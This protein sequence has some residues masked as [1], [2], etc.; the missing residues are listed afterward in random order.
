MNGRESVSGRVY[1]SVQD[2]ARDD[3]PPVSQE[4]A[5]R[6]RYSVARNE[7]DALVLSKRLWDID[8]QLPWLLGGVSVERGALADALTFMRAHYGAIFGN[9]RDRFFVEDMSI[10][11]Q[12]FWQEMDIFIFRSEGCVVGMMAG[13]PSDWSTYYVRTVAILPAFRK[14][15]VALRFFQR[16]RDVLQ[17]AGVARWEADVCA[18]NLASLNVVS[19]L[20]FIATGSLNSER[21]GALIRFTGFLCDSASKIYYRQFLDVPAFGREMSVNSKE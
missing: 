11:K 3:E 10:A 15:N 1:E 2:A 13:H 18:A 21:W 20:G 9:G 12:R 6:D 5:V 19:K 7:T 8:W 17:S 4:L 16:V 14:G